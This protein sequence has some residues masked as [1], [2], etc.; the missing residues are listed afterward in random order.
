M[1][2]FSAGWLGLRSAAD[3]RARSRGLLSVLPRKYPAIIDLGAGTGANLRWLAP[4]LAPVQR[5][6]L[7]DNDSAL[8]EI[9]L[10]ATR[11]WAEQLGYEVKVVQA[12]GRHLSIN[13]D[14]L[15]ATVRTL[16]LDLSKNAGA[17]DMPAGGLVTASALFDLVSESWLSRLVARIAESGSSILWALNYDGRVSLDPSLSDDAGML[18]LLN[19]HQLTDKGFGPALGP[20]AWL[21]AQGLLEQSGLDVTIVDSSW[22]CDAADGELIQAFINGWAEAAVD[23]APTDRVSI[24]QWCKQRLALAAEGKLRL[25]V[26]HRDLAARAR[27]AEDR[28]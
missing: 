10:S 21:V 20:G 11:A 12:S 15:D 27:G 7:V 9:A 19:R 25:T 23:I 24:Q 26:G 8:L 1:S 5:W 4:E 28:N 2:G 3:R 17:L 13:G 6:T 22:H 16:A 18:A 14:R